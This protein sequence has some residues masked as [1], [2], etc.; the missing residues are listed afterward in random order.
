VDPGIPN[1][2]PYKEQLLNE[3]EQKR[4]QVSISFML[5]KCSTDS[6]VQTY[7]Q[8]RPKRRLEKLSSTGK[9]LPT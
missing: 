7:R 3:I 6:V 2:Y 1:S 5:D 8:S 4:M 9:A